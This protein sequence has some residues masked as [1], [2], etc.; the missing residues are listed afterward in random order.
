MNFYFSSSID[1]YRFGTCCAVFY[2]YFGPIER[3]W[4]FFG[5]STPRHFE[6]VIFET[7]AQH[8]Q[9]YYIDNS[10]SFL[11]LCRKQTD[12]VCTLN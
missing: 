2:S 4:V 1:K 11:V 10:Y 5:S 3:F 7:T 8:D 9:F 12:D 6:N